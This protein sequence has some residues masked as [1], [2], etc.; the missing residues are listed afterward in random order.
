MTSVAASRPSMPNLDAQNGAGFGSFFR[1]HGWLAPGVR[2]FRRIGFPAKAMWVSLAFLCPLVLM[3]VFL[4]SAAQESIATA[5]SER[6]GV[7]YVRPLLSLVGEAQNRRRAATGQ[8]SDLAQA[9]DQVKAAFA[10]LAA[11]QTELGKGLGLERPYAELQKLHESLMQTPVAG[12]TDTTFQIHG[13]FIASA[14]SLLRAVADGSQLALDPEL[15]TYH[16]MSVAVI[17]GPLQVE[18][19]A[20]LRELGSTILKSREIT[21][22]RRDR[23]NEWNAIWA[24]LDGDLENSFQAVVTATPEVDQLVDMKGADDASIAFR[25]AVMKRLLGPELVGD[26]ASFQSLG[27]DAGNQQH[28]LNMTLLDRLDARLQGRIDKERRQ[29]IL[30]LGIALFFVLVAGYLMLA[31]YKVMMGGLREVTGHLEQITQ[32]NLTTCPSPWGRDEAAQLM[33]TLGTM[34]QSLRRIVG[35]VL[36]SSGEV[37]TASEEIASASHDLSQRTE[38]TAA[39]LQQTASSMEEIASTVKQTADTVD[40]ALTIVRSNAKAATRGGQVI[41]EVVQTM[42]GIRTS[43]NKIGEIIGVIDSIA[44]QTNILA[45]NAA[46]EAARAGEQGRGFA[47]VATEVRALAG[48]SA[49]AAREIKSLITASIEQVEAGNKVAAEAGT[50]IADIVAN[51]DRIA[52]LM[53]TI[54]NATREQSAGVAQVGN[55]VADLDRSTQQNAALVEQTSAAA[56]SLSDQSGRLATE[57]AFFRM[58]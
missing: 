9:Q 25:D 6:A 58:N 26:A 3:L 4:V 1:Y 28:T 23:I 49:A 10:Q 38:Q 13:E 46:V 29:I 37:R 47:V 42:E 50:T 55:A 53:D 36:N 33:V 35:N 2:L 5:R 41:G 14:L 8:A 48:R 7:A 31:F 39:N 16:L 51:A 40:G 24:Y 18:N 12:D 52:S 44:F 43:S 19:T 15:D 11:K 20:K 54:S 21:P 27:N 34:Q 30:E 17:R 57:V 22:P 32:G 56:G 45:L